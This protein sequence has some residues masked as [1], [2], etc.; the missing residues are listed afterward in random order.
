MDISQK[1]NSESLRYLHNLWSVGHVEVGYRLRA[2][3]VE[4]H[5]RRPEGR[6]LSLRARDA[7][8]WRPW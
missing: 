2:H 3:D 8:R 4:R 5:G 7:Q 1:T 6:D